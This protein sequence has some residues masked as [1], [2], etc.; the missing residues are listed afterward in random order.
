MR[1]RFPYG[2][3]KTME[4]KREAG[5]SGA[6][7]SDVLIAFDKTMEGKSSP[8]DPEQKEAKPQKH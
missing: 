7:G 3:D 5:G 6:F 2:F 8:E 1:E 4:G